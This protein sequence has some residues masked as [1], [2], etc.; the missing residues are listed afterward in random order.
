MYPGKLLYA[1]PVLPGP[2]A[3]PEHWLQQAPHHGDGRESG[4]GPT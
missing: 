3:G 2:V 1:L 4:A